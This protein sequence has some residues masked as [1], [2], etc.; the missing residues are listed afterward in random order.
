MTDEAESPQAVRHKAVAIKG[1]QAGQ[2][3]V[4][5]KGHGTHAEAMLALAFANGVLVREDA[6]LT[7]MLDA[8]EVD[9]AIPLQALE[10]VC[11]VLTH[12]YEQ[13]QAWPEGWRVSPGIG[14]RS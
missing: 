10:A 4:L 6:A 14:E 9:S 13:T 3:R 11:T 7:Q 2:A 1:A 5:A 12:V 8:F